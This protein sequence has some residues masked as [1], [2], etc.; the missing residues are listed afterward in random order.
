MGDFPYQWESKLQTVFKASQSWRAILLID[1]ADLFLG[2]RTS[3][4]DYSKRIL[5]SLFLRQLEYFQ[6][7]MFLTTNRYHAIDEAFKSRIH[8]AMRYPDLDVDARRSIWENFLKRAGDIYTHG[9]EISP[10][11]IDLLAQKT[12][13][14]REIR[15]IVKSA[16]LL[17]SR[18]KQPLQKNHLDIV[19]KVE[20]EDSV[21]QELDNEE[22]KVNGV[23]DAH[24]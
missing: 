12:L 5:T 22:G 19:W 10:K 18:T 1:E 11:D 20:H 7:I 6:G 23:K 17:A 3:N 14:G 2:K 9:V 8:V 24:H 4:S 15:N 16:Q 21:W 13:N